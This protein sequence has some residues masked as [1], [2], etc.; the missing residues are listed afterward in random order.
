MGLYILWVTD[1]FILF[2]QVQNVWEP[3]GV[4]VGDDIE[5]SGHWKGSGNPYVWLQTEELIFQV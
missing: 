1:A 3:Q 5:A 4:Q 2:K